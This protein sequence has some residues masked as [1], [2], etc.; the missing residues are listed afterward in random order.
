MLDP[1]EKSTRS[2][3]TFSGDIEVTL[4]GRMWNALDWMDAETDWSAE[5]VA[6]AAW[7]AA[8]QSE[9]LGVML[10]PGNFENEFRQA[11][12]MTIAHQHDNY[13]EDAYS[14]HKA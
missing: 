6:N 12:E 13:I 1:T 8:K 5:D 14:A 4:E 3:S 11:F 10:I 9:M 2:I 7:K